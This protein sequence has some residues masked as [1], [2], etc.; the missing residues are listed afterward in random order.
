MTFMDNHRVV[1]NLRQLIHTAFQQVHLPA[2]KILCFTECCRE[3]QNCHAF[4]SSSGLF[5]SRNISMITLCWR[6]TTKKKYKIIRVV[7]NLCWFLI[8]STRRFHGKLKSSSYLLRLAK[9]SLI[10]VFVLT[11]IQSKWKVIDGSEQMDI[12]RALNSFPFRRWHNLKCSLTR[13]NL[14]A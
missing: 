4:I 14:K 13:R 3:C 12:K 1:I 6:K 9:I 10:K 5:S 8:I 11:L 2:S 7:I